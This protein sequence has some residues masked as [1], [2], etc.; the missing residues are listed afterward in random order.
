[1][2]ANINNSSL[3]EISQQIDSATLYGLR[4]SADQV[5]A[6]RARRWLAAA[7]GGGAVVAMG[8]LGIEGIEHGSDGSASSVSLADSGHAPSG[9]TYAQPAVPAMSLGPTASTASSPKSV[10]MNLGPTMT[11]GPAPSTLATPFAVPAH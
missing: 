8:V 1:L 7:V 4:M 2:N 11:D 9:T 5:A 3:L 10:N 6:E